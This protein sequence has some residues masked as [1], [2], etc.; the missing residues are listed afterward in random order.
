MM[1]QIKRNSILCPNCRKL[2][3]ADEPICP[4]C[5]LLRP[6]SAF[7][8]N[9]MIKTMG[10]AQRVAFYIIAINVFMFLVSLILS[11]RNIGMTMNPLYTMSPDDHVLLALGASGTYPIIRLG[12]WWSLI[13]ANYL[14]GNLLHI[15]F[16]MLMFWQLVPLVVK[17][18]GSYRMISIYTLGGVAGYVASFFAG[19]P[20]TIGASAAVC[21][22]VGSLLYFGKSRGGL[23]GQTVYKQLSGWVVSLFIFGFLIPN[24]NNWAHGG[25][26]LGGIAVGWLLGYNDI[27][28]EKSYHKTLAFI[29]AIMTILVLA[30]ALYHAV[31]WKFGLR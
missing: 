28:S 15:G 13:A 26:I 22:L 2:I 1:K 3:S 30:W 23:Y 27:K 16:N 7:K 25:G 14:H 9:P 18:Y 20:L 8:N 31:S 5:S 17:E 19:I 11:G 10:D 21:S 4:Y 29:C 12:Y 24:I 6:G